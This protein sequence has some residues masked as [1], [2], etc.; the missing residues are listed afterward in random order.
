MNLKKFIADQPLIFNLLKLGGTKSPQPLFLLVHLTLACNLCCPDC[1]QSLDN[2]YKP[3][4]KQF[5]K[6]EDFKNLLVQARQ[7]WFQPRIHFFG[8]EPLLHPNFAIL[9]KLTDQTGFQSSI[10][11]N[12]IL[13]K[14]YLSQIICPLRASA[15]FCFTQFRPP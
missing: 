8:G 5:I 11:T 4:K 14:K 10:T 12:G 3:F 6:L 1:Y 9:L 13:L 2:F 15:C 7:F